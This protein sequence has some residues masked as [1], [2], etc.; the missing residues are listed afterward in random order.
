M[1]ATRRVAG[2]DQSNKLRFLMEGWINVN[3]PNAYNVPHDHPGSF[4]SGAYYVMNDHTGEA[5][6]LGG[7]ISFLGPHHPPAGQAVVK[8]PI[9]GGNHTLR[10]ASGTLLLF[11]SN[12]KHWVHPNMSASDRITVAF[13]ATVVGGRPAKQPA[14]EAAAAIPAST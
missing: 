4:W 6:S 8:A 9:F 10:P 12:A 7:A 14:G 11:P 3:P 13:N 2:A 5:E 1:D